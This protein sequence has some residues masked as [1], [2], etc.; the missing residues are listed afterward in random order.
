[1]SMSFSSRTLLVA[2]TFFAIVNAVAAFM[3]YTK[4]LGEDGTSVEFCGTGTCFSA[5][6]SLGDSKDAQK[7]CADESHDDGCVQTGIPGIASAH[8]CYCS[9][10][11]CNSAFTPSIVLPLLVLPAVLQYIL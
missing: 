6:G 3:C 10:P 5:G 7:G 1:M 8:V 2:L 9:T 4:T 11:F